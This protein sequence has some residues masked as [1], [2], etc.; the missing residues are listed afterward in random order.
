MLCGLRDRCI[1]AMLA[2]QRLKN[3]RTPRTRT[4]YLGFADRRFDD[5]TLCA[6]KWS[7]AWDLHPPRRLHR[8]ECSLA[9]LS[10]ESKSGA[11]ARTRTSN[12]RLRKAACRTL[13]P[14][15]QNGAPCRSCADT[16]SLEETHAAVTPMTRSKMVAASG[17]APDSPRLQ[18]GANL[19][20]L[21]SR[22]VPP[23]GIAPW[24]P[25]YQPGALLLSYGGM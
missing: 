25:G 20:Q 5:F 22:V 15:E 10:P 1:A 23:H 11:P 9:T 3:G 17:I 18:R 14:R 16:V 19:S 24:S 6:K 2:T 13:T 4:G 21:H 8:P 12:L 7:G